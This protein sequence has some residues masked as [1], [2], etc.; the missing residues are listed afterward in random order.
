MKSYSC[1][2]AAVL[3]IAVSVSTA[4]AATLKVAGNGNDGDACGSN[5][6]PCRTISKAISRASAGDMILVGP[7]VYGDVNGDGVF[8]AGAGDEVSGDPTR[9]IVVD[10]SV[11]IRST[12]GASVTMLS[13]PNCLLSTVTLV[14]I[15]ASGVELGAKGKGFTF[16]SSACIGDVVGLEVSAAT[17]GVT[18]AGNTFATD[19][20]AGTLDGSNHILKNNVLRRAETS[21]ALGPPSLV[22]QLGGEGHRVENNVGENGTFAT[23]PGSRNIVFKR[24]RM[25]AQAGISFELRGSGHVLEG[26]VSS[27]AL[28]A[29]SCSAGFFCFGDCGLA[30]GLTWAKNIAQGPCGAGFTIISGA[31]HVLRD[32]VAADEAVGFTIGGS[33]TVVTLTGN[34]AVACETAG[35]MLTTPS[36]ATVTNNSFVGNRGVGIQAFVDAGTTISGNN[37]YGNDTAS[38]S[39]CGIQ[40]SASGLLN[41]PGNYWGAKEGPGSDPADA[42]CPGPGVIDT[43]APASSPF[44]VSAPKYP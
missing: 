23:L 37:I 12:G 18:I 9:V 27:S 11:T 25:L 43:G 4:T 15:E 44:A 41:A 14:A 39:N 22:F 26:N 30:G 2:G 19:L 6:E 34:V 29:S 17:N 40:L 5:T 42:A 35:L 7:G 21:D 20:Y 1:A 31:G 28:G 3:L 38:G 36:V 33:A 24:N 13:G 8:D 10:R 32:N 16:R